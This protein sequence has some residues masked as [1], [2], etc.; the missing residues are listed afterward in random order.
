M[1][2][3]DIWFDNDSSDGRIKIIV[4]NRGKGE[5]TEKMRKGMK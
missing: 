2:N 1:G 5:M 3:G 4:I